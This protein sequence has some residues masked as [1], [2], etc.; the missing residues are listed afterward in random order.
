MAHRERP[1]RVWAPVIDQHAT[2]IA[3]NPV[4][5]CLKQC[6]YCFL[7]DR[8]QT[9]T[10]PVTLAGPAEAVEALVASR[11]YA[12]ARPVAL[13]TWTDVMDQAV[14]REHLHAV[15][16]G[17]RA[18]QLRNPLVLITKCHIPDGTIA[19]LQRA[20]DAGLPVMVFLSYSGLDREIERGIRHDQLIA[21]FGRLH[22]AGI[23]IV[24]YWR[25]V[26]PASATEPTMRG[27]LDLAARYARASVVAGLKVETEAM[28]DRLAPQWPELATAPGVR[29]A[30]GVYPRAFWDFTHRTAELY[31]GYPV[32]HSTACAV[33]ALLERPDAHGIHQSRVCQA[34]VCPDAQRRRCGMAGARRAPATT[35]R[36][37]AALVERGLPGVAF[38]V[39]EDDGRLLVINAA[40]GTATAAALTQDL[41]MRVE[42]ARDTGDRYWASGTAG[43]K[44]VIL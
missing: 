31:P 17:M 6:Q 5:G 21:N 40:V 10:R 39:A 43:A 30:E 14:T 32:F 3:V 22:A 8:G 42:V 11:W 16:E 41:G 27:V 34:N 12:P 24:H 1:R 28:R 29:E 2:W 7:L 38:H 36:I 15:L 4:Q 18:R 35:G 19:C 26:L 25:P 20:R 44:P 9:H 13:Y 33:A 37:A 23:P